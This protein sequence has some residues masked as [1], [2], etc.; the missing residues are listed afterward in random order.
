MLL[1]SREGAMIFKISWNILSNEFNI[2][3][4]KKCKANFVGAIK[5]KNPEKYKYEYKYEHKGGT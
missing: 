4:A 3:N 1:A 2:D 5:L